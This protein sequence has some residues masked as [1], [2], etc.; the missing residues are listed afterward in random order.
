MFLIMKIR[1]LKRITP[2]NKTVRRDNNGQIA[3][4]TNSQRLIV[5]RYRPLF[6]PTSPAVNAMR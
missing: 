6:V 5:M 2:G 4:P 3:T 1:T